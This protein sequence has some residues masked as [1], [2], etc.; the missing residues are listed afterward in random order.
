MKDID[1]N[2]TSTEELEKLIRLDKQKIIKMLQSLRPID[3][4]FFA[5]IIEDKVFCQELLQVI[6][7]DPNLIVEYT[8]TQEEIRNLEGRGVRLDAYCKL[9][10]GK[11]VN[12]EI[13]K[14][15]KDDHVRRVRY[16]TSLLTNQHTQKGSLFKDIPDVIVIYISTFDLFQLNQSY[17]KIIRQV[18]FLDGSIHDSEIAQNGTTE[19]YINTKIDDHTKIA[20]L[21]KLFVDNTTKSSEFPN[22]E[23]IKQ[24]YQKTEEGGSKMYDFLMTN[25][26]DVIDAQCNKV[27]EESREEGREE[28]LQE[29]LQKGMEKGLQKGLQ[30]KAIQIALKMLQQKLQPELISQITELSLEQLKKL[31]LQLTQSH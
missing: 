22:M 28:G 23:R 26:K 11:H 1:I 9:G 7:D 19:I 10:N 27:R 12:I 6:L 18:Q 31:Q 29:G 13:Q 30:E 17:Y 2:N 20:R 3:D 4:L 14:E 24:R 5:I 8:N 15:D 16:N 21:M 25:F